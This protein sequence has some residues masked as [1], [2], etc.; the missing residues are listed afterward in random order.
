MS[1]PYD[2]QFAGDPTAASSGVGGLYGG[3][4]GT[5]LAGG[6]S[7][8]VTF[9]IGAGPKTTSGYP[10]SCLLARL[11][12]ILFAGGTVATTSGLSWSIFSCSDSGPTRYDTVAYA[13]GPTVGAV[14]SSVTGASIDLPPGCYKATLTNLDASNSINVALTLGSVG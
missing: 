11:Q 8:T 14:A 9:A 5:A 4:T 6:A 13:S 1:L 2:P 3:S 10:T 12:A 7:V